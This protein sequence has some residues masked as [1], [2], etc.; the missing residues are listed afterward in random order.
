M[1][2]TGVSQ[3]RVDFERA[4]LRNQTQ[5]RQRLK[6]RFDPIQWR[7]VGDELQ[8]RFVGVAG[9]LKI[10]SLTFE[11]Q[12]KFLQ[13]PDAHTKWDALLLPLVSV[14]LPRFGFALT[15]VLSA[16]PV[17]RQSFVD[18]LAHAYALELARGL[19]SGPLFA[20]ETRD[21]AVAELRG[22]FLV[23]SQVSHLLAPPG[24]I[25]CR[26]THL[27][28]DNIYS[29]VM[30]WAA[31]RLAA[32]ARIASTR[33]RLMGMVAQLGALP[34]APLPS[35]VARVE[36]MPQHLAYREAFELARWLLAGGSVS[37][38]G[39]SRA[40]TS[41]VV[42]MER[43]FERFVNGLMREVVQNARRQGNDWHSSPQ[44]ASLLATEIPEGRSVWTIPDDRLIA[45][46]SSQAV[47]DAKYKLTLETTPRRT[48]DFADDFYQVVAAAKAAK[49]DRAMLVYPR[50]ELGESQGEH[51]NLRLW[52]IAAADRERVVWVGA[53]GISLTQLAEAGGFA[54]IAREFTTAIEKLLTL[55]KAS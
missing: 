35:E 31:V 5:L 3:S 12:P 21:E 37:F 30:A 32:S 10:G 1:L 36:L 51:L 26:F 6:A 49:C 19:R 22:Q 41:V 53:K 20:Y 23:E 27:Q 39:G 42:N 16:K 50:L 34:V 18:H 44:Q 14:A 2:S 43:L 47:I 28:G 17:R 7:T 29:R 54:R 46:G 11:I 13:G 55:P 48:S 4:L 24:R 8:V 15:S 33:G 45:G 9:T 25:D 40:G 52:R 38:A